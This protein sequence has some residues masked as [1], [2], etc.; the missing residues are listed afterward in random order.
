[1]KQGP[2]PSWAWL[3]WRQSHMD[4]GLTYV[5]TAQWVTCI[6]YGAIVALYADLWL[7]GI[8]KSVS[9]S[10]RPSIFVK[11]KCLR[12]MLLQQTSPGGL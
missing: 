11:G 6:I 9:G 10:S 5:R 2:T 4:R 12:L 7:C 1:M 3:V 8:N